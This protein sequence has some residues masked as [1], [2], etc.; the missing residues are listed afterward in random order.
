MVMDIQ[1]VFTYLREPVVGAFIGYIT[2]DVAI[3]LLFRPLKPWRVLG[4][5]LPL[6]PGVLPAKRHE[7]AEK[8]GK[9]VGS[10]LLTSE[11]VKRGLAKESFRRELQWALTEKLDGFLDRDIG[12]LET[13]VPPDS[14]R[15]IHDLADRLLG[16]GIEE[17]SHY[18]DSVS[19]E[20]DMRG[21]LRRWGDDVLERDPQSLLSPE[22]YEIFRAN[23][24]ERIRIFINSETVRNSFE[25]FID[26]GIDE[27]FNS[28]TT[29]RELLP[30]SLVEA[31]ATRLEQEITSILEGMLQDPE[32]LSLLKQKIKDSLQD[33]LNSLDGISGFVTRFINLDKLISLFPGF[34]DRI[35]QEIARWLRDEKTLRHIV[36]SLKLRI[37]SLLDQTLAGCLE[38]IPY[39][40][41]AALR[42]LGRKRLRD[43][44]RSDQASEM[45][46]SLIEQASERLK[47]Q[48]LRSVLDDALSAES[49]RQ[50]SEAIE[51]KV[52]AVLRSPG[53]RETVE[54]TVTENAEKWLFKRNIGRLSSIFPS[55]AKEELSE[56]IFQH[57][58]ELLIIEVPPLIETL[59]VQEIVEEKVNSLDIL[60]MEGLLLDIMKEQFM[61]LNLFGAMLGF[62]IG[63][64]NLLIPGL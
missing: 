3:R 12:T 55:H 38:T 60:Q 39:K 23:A 53:V 26:N 64:L 25:T 52:I 28:E 32:F 17:F 13:L 18:L 11:D 42:R 48:S 58:S 8:I 15:W 63:I 21:Y 31:L 10:H 62:I 47:G 56:I 57:L 44:L 6:T 34:L 35:E 61:F 54:H 16:L 20:D 2:T 27:L 43:F 33:S 59:N 9:M 50:V 40:K 4:V 5:R 7:F 41:A 1:Q 30:A 49:L 45:V 37:D 46:I 36:G 22:Q 14:Y 51:N 24:A 29:L 19:F